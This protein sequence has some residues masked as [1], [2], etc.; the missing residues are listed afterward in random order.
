MT[1]VAVIIG[2]I[3]SDWNLFMKITG[4]AAIVPLLLSGLLSGALVDGDRLRANFKTETKEDRLRRNKWTFKFFLI[5]LP[6]LSLLIIIV[7]L[8][9]SF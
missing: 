3:T 4:F 7:I 2:F 1:T 9:L 8:G 5:S 6:N